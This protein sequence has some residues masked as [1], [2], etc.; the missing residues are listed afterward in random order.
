[1]QT[2]KTGEI[3]YNLRKEKGITQ[4]RLA[5]FLGVSTP[6]VS[7][8]E[9]G[10][11]YPDITLLP[12]IASYF[13]VT[14]DHLMDFAPDL[15][16]EE[17]MEIYHRL[18]DAFSVEDFDKVYSECK[19]YLKKY[20][21]S[22]FLHLQIGNLLLNHLDRLP[23]QARIPEILDF[24]ASVFKRVVLST[25]DP[26]LRHEANY[27][28]GISYMFLGRADEVIEVMKDAVDTLLPPEILLAQAH[29]MK[30][31]NTEAKTILQGYVFQCLV[32]LLNACPALAFLNLDSPEKSLRWFGSLDGAMNNF[33]FAK[34]N[35]FGEG[36]MHLAYA[37]ALVM[38][39]NPEGALDQLEYFIKV[40]TNPEN[41]PVSFGTSELFDSISGLY[42][43]LD[44]GKGAP[45]SDKTIQDSCLDAI[46]K[47][48]AFTPL[49]EKER[50]QMLLSELRAFI[51]KN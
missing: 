37:K 3:I 32:G 13:G 18:S 29:Q 10:Q 6:A 23:D 24:A 47:D 2:L 21:N 16:K 42:A 9:T 49:L 28:L 4:E 48:P 27:S 34:V 26:K 30:G 25:A 51:E 44:L 14:I 5:E 15:S 45:R 12:E 33:E 1:M 7:K 40:A 17:A 43:K 38:T 20:H 50:Y 19:S 41:Y 36:Q 46:T 11:S 39:G 31:N 35:P 22:Y 8:W